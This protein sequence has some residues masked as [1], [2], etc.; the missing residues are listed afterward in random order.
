MDELVQILVYAVTIGSVYALVAFSYSLVF[1][2]TR[3]VNFAQG[4]LVVVGGYLAWWLWSSVFNRDVSMI[5]VTMITI[6]LAALVGL[7]FDLVAVEPLG[8]FDPTT[9]I[10]WLVTTFGAAVV[11]QEIVAQ[12]ISDTG[13]S[14]PSLIGSIL[15]WRGSVVR[16]VAISPS[17]LI[18]VGT[19]LILVVALELLQA[20]T[21][22]G[23]AFRAVAQDR[24]AAS[25]MG[26]DPK[27]MVRL[28]FLVAGAITGL[29][30]VL[31]APRYGVRFSIGLNLGL[32]GFVAAVLGGLGSTRGAIVG[33][34]VVGLVE[35][36]VGV[37]STRAESYRPIVVFVVFVLVLTMRPTGLLG[38]PV[39]EKV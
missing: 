35:G 23:R 36:V 34:Y 1:S 3:I 5:L 27:A 18:L 6:L 10:A 13:Q 7:V 11:V 22:I 24:Q 8:E 20:R 33:G 28:S 17:D 31:V 16:N 12:L 39:V 29:A 15:G 38:R 37:L 30:G 14:I 2:T 26:I 25:L 21:R 32:A 19:T 9:N 4:T